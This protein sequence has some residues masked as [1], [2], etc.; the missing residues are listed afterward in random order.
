MLGL[1]VDVQVLS[2]PLFMALIYGSQYL[3]MLNTI[4]ETDTFFI[5]I[6]FQDKT[7]KVQEISKRQKSASI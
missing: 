3:F 5:G 7:R 4:F 1:H 6:S 2:V